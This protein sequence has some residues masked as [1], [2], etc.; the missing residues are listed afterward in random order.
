MRLHG[1]GYYGVVQYMGGQEPYHAGTIPD[2]EGRMPRMN[3]RRPDMD[4]VNAYT[5]ATSVENVPG[6]DFLSVR[7]YTSV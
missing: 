7:T 4:A 3:R 6:I 5:L 1:K 2:L